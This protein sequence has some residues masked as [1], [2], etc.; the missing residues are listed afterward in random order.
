ML[1]KIGVKRSKD[2]GFEIKQNWNPSQITMKEAWKIADALRELAS[3]MDDFR[4]MG[5]SRY[6]QF[7]PKDPAEGRTS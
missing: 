5:E 2:G 7:T 6:I 3:E 4:F 1:G